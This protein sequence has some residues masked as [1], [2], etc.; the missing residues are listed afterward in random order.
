MMLPIIPGLLLLIIPEAGLTILI[1]QHLLLVI[2][3]I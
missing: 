3:L 2:K 1:K